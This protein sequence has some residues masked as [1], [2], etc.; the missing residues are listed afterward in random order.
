MNKQDDHVDRINF[1]QEAS[2]TFVQTVPNIAQFY[3][4]FVFCGLIVNTQRF[5]C[6]ELSDVQNIPL[7]AKIQNKS[8]AYCSA[9]FLTGE[10]CTYRMCTKKS[11]MVF[12]VSTVY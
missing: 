4:Y 6:K 7:H 10:N 9:L 5:K 2:N 11:S 3:M 8:C 1:L 12:I